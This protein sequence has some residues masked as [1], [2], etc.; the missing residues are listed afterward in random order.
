VIAW[1]VADVD[2]KEHQYQAAPHDAVDALGV[3]ADFEAAQFARL[4]GQPVSSAWMRTI[5]LGAA[6]GRMAIR[7][8][9]ALD[10]ISFREI[11]AGRN[12]IELT[13]A[14][15]GRATAEGF[16]DS[17]R[18]RISDVIAAAAKAKGSTPKPATP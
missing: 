14:A 15:E 2:G 7:D 11:F 3:Y 9:N 18:A 12:M 8:G 17:V 5:L 1:T 10:D 16:S 13:R 4:S 6:P